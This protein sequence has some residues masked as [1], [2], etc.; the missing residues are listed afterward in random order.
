MGS[1]KAEVSP[2]GS[3]GPVDDRS[4]NRISTLVGDPVCPALATVLA[5]AVES[6]NLLAARLA[7]ATA[8]ADATLAL[9]T[10]D[11]CWH[12]NHDS[13]TVERVRVLPAVV[14]RLAADSPAS[15]AHVARKYAIITLL[16]QAPAATQ[17]KLAL[18][19]GRYL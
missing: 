18:L 12:A 17:E 19:L 14:C 9:V 13:L 10:D 7:R 15:A 6:L 11:D 4:R 16:D 2:L 3:A 5:A 8:I 1:L